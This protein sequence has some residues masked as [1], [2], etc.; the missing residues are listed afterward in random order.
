MRTGWKLAALAIL[1]VLV[2]GAYLLLPHQPPVFE[3]KVEMLPETA[4]GTPEPYSAVATWIGRLLT[5][6]VVVAVLGVLAWVTRHVHRRDRG[7]DA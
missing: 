5:A 2:V 7:P 4:T 3:V 6:A 1:V